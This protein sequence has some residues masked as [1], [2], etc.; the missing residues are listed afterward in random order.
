MPRHCSS[1][2]VA[3]HQ[4]YYPT[5][6][7]R[8]TTQYP[9]NNR[10]T[11]PSPGKTINADKINFGG[12]NHYYAKP[13]ETIVINTAKGQIPYKNPKYMSISRNR[14][15]NGNYSYSINTGGG[16]RKIASTDSPFSQQ[17]KIQADQFKQSKETPKTTN[18]KSSID[19][20]LKLT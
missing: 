5:K 10:T 19:A 9:S 8:T 14:E 4:Q 20:T 15:K 1:R 2:T 16:H 7:C 3:R 17:R 12:D 6:Q 18:Q 11:T 13:G